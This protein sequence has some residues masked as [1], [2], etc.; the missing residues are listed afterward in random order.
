MKKALVSP[1]IP[2]TIYALALST[3]SSWV[4]LLVATFS[5]NSSKSIKFPL[6]FK[7]VKAFPSGS[8]KTG[9]KSFYLE[10]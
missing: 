4:N 2:C 9:V 7:K 1:F 5:S 10:S 3:A 6:Y 8:K